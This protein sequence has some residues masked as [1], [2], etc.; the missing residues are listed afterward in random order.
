M[1]ALEDLQNLEY[2][3]LVSKITTELGNHLGID[4]KTLAEFVINLHQQT[5]SPEEFKKIIAS[6]GVDFPDS[7]IT[8]IDRL[9]LTMHPKH[10]NKRSKGS[11]DGSE[12]GTKKEMDLDTKA[13]NLESK[14]KSENRKKEG[15]GGDALAKRSRSPSPYGRLARNYRSR[16]GSR[17]RGG[18]RKRG[19][20]RD[21][22]GRDRERRGKHRYG[23]DEDD[24]F[25]R[26]PVPELD[27]NPVLYKIYNGRVSGMKDF[28][29]FVSLQNV[30]GKVDGLVHIS[31]I[32][33]DRVNHPADLLSRGQSVKVKVVSVQGTRIGLSMK[34]SRLS[35]SPRAPT[36]RG[37]TSRSECPPPSAGRLSSSSLPGQFRPPITQISTRSTMRP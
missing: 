13:R 9:V 26:P 27:E 34:D 31:A 20:E 12:E 18:D 14:S 17:S 36:W 3:S 16:S 2:L 4:D 33:L 25:R 32:R 5:S 37:W 30:K 21:D 35:A 28:G 6:H 22:F 23:G 8:S 29:V 10:K 24:D 15:G 19:R 11:G 7:L 1:E